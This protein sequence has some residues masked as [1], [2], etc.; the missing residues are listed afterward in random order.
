MKDEMVAMDTRL[1]ARLRVAEQPG[2]LRNFAVV[3]AHSGDSPLWLAGLLLV[4]WRGSDFWKHEARLDLIG[5]AAT[6]ILVQALK[7]AFRRR[8]PAGEWGQSYRKVDPHSFPSGHAARAAM[9]AVTAVALGPAWWAILLLAWAPLVALARVAMG[10]HY[11][12]DV[13]A[14]VV[15]GIACGI[16]VVIV[17]R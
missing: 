8:R 9:L 1:S 14:G 2:L 17:F 5:V 3:F 6:A 7:L 15:C 11:L 12:S 13:V 16:A 10:V 4:L